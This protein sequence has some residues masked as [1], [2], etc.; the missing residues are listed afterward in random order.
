MGQEAC[1]YTT[2]LE[3]EMGWETRKRGGRYYTRSS[4][5]DGRV[6]REYLGC[7]P[8]AVLAAAADQARIA[9]REAARVQAQ[10]AEEHFHS[11]EEPLDA[12]DRT[13]RALALMALNGAGYHQH[14][15]GEW[16]R[17]REHR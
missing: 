7:G 13:C 1:G 15:R 17:R 16:R 3:N 9:E 12:L 5:V 4:K 2:P 14:H 6:I 11:L 10:V 8:V